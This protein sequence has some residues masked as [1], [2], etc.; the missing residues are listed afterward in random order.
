MNTPP[1]PAATGRLLSLDAYRGFIMVCLAFGGFGLAKTAELHLRTEPDSGLWRFLLAQW[2]HGEW[3]GWGFWDLIMPAFMFMVGMAM[4]FSQARRVND[5]QTR[6]Q[7][8]RH[9]A[10]RTGVLILLGIFLTSHAQPKSPWSLTNT[11]VQIGLC[12]PLVYWCLGRGWRTQAAVA[13]GSLVVTWFLFVLHGGAATPGPG[14][15]AEWA[16]RHH[17]GLG[18][19]W[20]KN[21]NL[22]HVLD[23][24][25]LNMLPQPTPFVAN[26]GGY[27][28]LNFLPSLATM[29]GGLMCG[30]WVRRPEVTEGRKLRVLLQA[31][32]ALLV[33]GLVVG[34]S[35][36]CPI[37]KRIWTPS[38]GLICT[39]C[40]VLMLAAFYYAVDIRG[41][42]RWTFPLIVAGANSIALYCMGMLLKSWT[43]GI[44]QRY[45]GKEIF[46]AAGP[47]W[48]PVLRACA[49][50]VT[51]WFVTLWMY[52]H[53]FFVRI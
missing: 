6:G 37:I 29:I 4:P 49:V 1:A 22:A 21:S 36:L 16:A 34:H 12:Y 47:V 40:C 31:G 3:V 50:G 5:G 7:R 26:A 30:E 41:W 45:L 18:T 10:V 35:G 44:W 8:L 51:F 43:S 23:V 2:E 28:T 33:L 13:A 14:I 32:T 9:L 15:T 19:A 48:E 53:K 24:W 11:L 27:Q 52:R 20:W 38:F 25:L 42:R 39:G 46:L 17:A